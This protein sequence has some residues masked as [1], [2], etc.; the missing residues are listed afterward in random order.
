MIIEAEII[1]MAAGAIE[2]TIEAAMTTDHTS[3]TMIAQISTIIVVEDLD[4]MIATMIATDKILSQ[5][6]TLKMT[7]ESFSKPFL[8][9]I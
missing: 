1:I 2:I 5:V 6:T 4:R 7:K 8:I 9:I 3:T